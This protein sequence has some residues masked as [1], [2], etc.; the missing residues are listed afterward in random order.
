MHRVQQHVEQRKLDLPQRLQPALE[1]TRRQHLVEQGARQRLAGVDMRRHVFENLPLPAEVFHELAGQLHGI[2]LDAADARDIALVHLGQHVVQAVPEL[3]KQGGDI[4]VREQRR[5]A[6]RT[7]CEVA[8][9]VRNRRLQPAVVGA[10]PAGSDVV[11][12][13]A[14]ALAAAS[15]G[16]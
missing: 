2:P 10:Q 13:G 7:F 11:H 16:V 6:A 15:R 3:V 14:T 12:P 5:L 1:I 8:D 4:V 9:Q